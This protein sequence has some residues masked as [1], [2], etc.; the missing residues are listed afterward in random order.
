ML[1]HV[2]LSLEFAGKKCQIMQIEGLI[3]KGV[4]LLLY[5]I[6]LYNFHPTSFS[7]KFHHKHPQHPY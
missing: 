3:V 4:Y 6:P 5:S 7:F 2:G 1:K